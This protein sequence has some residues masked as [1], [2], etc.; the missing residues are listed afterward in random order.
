MRFLRWFKFEPP[1]V[2]VHV[3]IDAAEMDVAK[4]TEKIRAE[5][6]RAQRRNG[7]TVGIR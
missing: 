1:A 4:L 6:V 5:L 2:T 7:G 3:H